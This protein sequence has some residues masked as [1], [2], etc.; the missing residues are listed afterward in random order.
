M[1]APVD[2][3]QDGAAVIAETPISP[4]VESE[5]AV[6]KD[7]LSGFAPDTVVTSPE[8]NSEKIIYDT[9]DQGNVLGWHKEASNG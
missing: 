3:T 2:Q 7:D 5:S 9:D 6:L 1:D 8:G 4:I